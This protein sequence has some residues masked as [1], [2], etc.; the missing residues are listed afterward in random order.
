MTKSFNILRYRFRHGVG[1]IARAF[2]SVAVCQYKIEADEP[3]YDVF[4]EDVVFCGN[5]D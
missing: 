5:D 2:E 3:L 4:I 1:K